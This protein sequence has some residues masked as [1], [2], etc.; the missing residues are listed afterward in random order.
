[1][2]Y[3]K[4]SGAIIFKIEK[5]K[6]VYLLLYSNYWGFVKGL[7]EQGEQEEATAEREA[8]EEAGIKIKIIPG[9]KDK[10]KY[11]FKFEGE[12]ISKEAVFFVAQALSKD[13]K[14]SHEHN[15]FK[16]FSL[17]EALSIMKHKNQKEMLK[18][19]NDFILT[20]LKQKKL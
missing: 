16:W 14:I 11:M 6:P 7:V 3:N 1:M 19:A 4:S 8:Q 9:F 5:E 13:V 17:D 20:W 2:R 10:I 18:K 12:F 15:D